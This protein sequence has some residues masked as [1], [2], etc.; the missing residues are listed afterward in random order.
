VKFLK[1]FA[2][3]TSW[4][5]FRGDLSPRTRNIIILI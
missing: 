1:D 5:D 4:L 2:T 3:V